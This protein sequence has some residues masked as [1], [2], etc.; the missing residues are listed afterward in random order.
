MWLG[1]LINTSVQDPDAVKHIS[2][3]IRQ[4]HAFFGHEQPL[5][6]ERSTAEIATYRKC[7]E[8]LRRLNVELPLQ[9][10]KVT[11]ID[12]LLGQNSKRQKLM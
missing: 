9:E 11:W 8:I 6:M 12:P 7:K 1:P 5:Y 10:E 3:A 2:E 4:C